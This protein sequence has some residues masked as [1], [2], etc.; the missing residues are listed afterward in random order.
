MI[1]PAPLEP[2]GTTENFGAVNV[3]TALGSGDLELQ[4]NLEQRQSVVE[5]SGF[6]MM[7]IMIHD[8]RMHQ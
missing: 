3:D 5:A 8:I 6:I 7:K 4:K 1:S 2:L